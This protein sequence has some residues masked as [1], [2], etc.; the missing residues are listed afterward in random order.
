MQ[1]GEAVITGAAKAPNGVQEIEFKAI[2]P[3]ANFE[4]L[5][6]V[7]GNSRVPLTFERSEPGAAHQFKVAVRTDLPLKPGDK[8]QVEFFHPGEQAGAH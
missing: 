2:C 8:L 6:V 3:A 4:R 1:V 7:V 5:N